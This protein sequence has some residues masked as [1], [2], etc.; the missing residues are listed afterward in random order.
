MDRNRLPH[1]NAQP[2]RVPGYG[3]SVPRRPRKQL[4]TSISHKPYNLIQSPIKSEPSLDDIWYR[5]PDEPQLGEPGQPEK[6]FEL[7]TDS[8][9]DQL[10]AWRAQ[11]TVKKAA[12]ILGE[13]VAVKAGRN[14]NKSALQKQLAT[15][16]PKSTSYRRPD[17]LAIPKAPPQTINIQ[18]QLPSVS[19]ARLGIIKEAI[20]NRT[21]NIR[22]GIQDRTA[23]WFQSLRHYYRRYIVAGIAISILM[24]A[25]FIG[26]QFKH[27]ADLT[28]AEVAANT[29]INKSIA[30]A[31]ESSRPDFTPIQPKVTTQAGEPNGNKTATGYDGSRN[32]YSFKDEVGGNP[33]VVSQQPIPNK[34]SSATIAVAQ[35]AESLSAKESTQTNVGTAYIAT[36][37]KS[38]AQTIV[39]SKNDL[40]LF[41]QSP[42]KHTGLEW[43]Q[44]IDKLGS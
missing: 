6:L 11:K 21:T 34:F 4:Q 32:T 20:N 24:F 28:A 18:I 43:R 25:T 17:A 26:L 1:S 36:D 37:T 33:I 7:T 29:V 27:S 19:L 10:K 14:Q 44:Y 30:T 16:D 23:I 13:P 35:V 8:K 5:D 39:F 40:L 38:N 41:I 2:D 42:F 9:L 3:P 31:T 12:K 22:Q 15:I